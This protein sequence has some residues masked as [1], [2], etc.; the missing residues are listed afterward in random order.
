MAYSLLRNVADAEDAV[1]ETFVK[2]WRDYA[3]L[4]EDK[5]QAWIMKVCRNTCLDRIRRLRQSVEIHEEHFETDESQRPDTNLSMEQASGYLHQLIT[6][7]DEPGKSLV[8]LRD[9]HEHSY[10]EIAEIMG[11]TLT[12]V[13]VYLY[14]ARKKLGELWNR[15]YEQ[16]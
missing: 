8:V 2:L 5:V 11:L 12:Q 7:L 16:A 10:E 6:L 3:R 15:H 14:R 13:K 9:L 4:D 1:Q